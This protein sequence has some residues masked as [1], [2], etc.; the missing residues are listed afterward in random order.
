[1]STVIGMAVLV[2]LFLTFPLLTRE[3]RAT[4]CSSGGCW[5]EK[6]GFG[7]GACPGDEAESGTDVAH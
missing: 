5:K 7:C 6:V 3:R 2:A 4:E 1:M